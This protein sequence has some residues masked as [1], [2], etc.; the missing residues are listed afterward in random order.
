MSTL[1]KVLIVLLTLAS[2]FLCGTVVTYVAN[3]V[4]YKEKFDNQDSRYRAAVQRASNAEENFNKLKE[5]TD[6]AKQDLDDRIAA[7]E[8]QI[9]K[10]TAD[11]KTALS[12]ADLA[13]KLQQGSAAEVAAFAQTVALNEKRTASAE[14]TA[15]DLEAKLTTE[16][17]EH[18]QTA[19]TLLEKI[20]II[21]VL[22]D[23]LKRATEE[24][25]VLQN[26]RDQFLRQYGKITAPGEPVTTLKELARVAPPVKDIDLKGV[27]VDLDL[28]E[29][30]AEISLGKADGVKEGMRFH[31]TRGNQFICDTV[32]LDVL[33]EKATGWLELIKEGVQNQP[34]VNDT[35]STNL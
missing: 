13:R 23:R 3:A 34:K 18:E 19:A 6:Q 10:L 21:G 31:A 9:S 30:L 24:K 7:L 27:I 12:Q 1:T 28:Q 11:L 8:R 14:K 16:Q 33:P 17:A 15:A 26:E 5:E 25:T 20:A 22:E 4:D 29:R 32:I 35:I 2:I